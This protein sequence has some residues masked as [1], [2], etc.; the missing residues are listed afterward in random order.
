LGTRGASLNLE[1]ALLAE[2]L[3]EGCGA[4]VHLTRRDETVPAPA[5]KVRMAE[6][7]GAD[8]FLTIGRAGRQDLWTA[9][10]HPGSATGLQWAELFLH[11]ARSLM[12]PD[13]TVAVT[14]S[15]NYLLRHTACPALEVR[16]PGPE[17][18]GREM[19]LSHR[20]WQRAEARAV[21]LS[22][23]SLFSQGNRDVRTLDVAAVIA[24]L[25][26][27][28]PVEDVEWAE[29]DGN[30]AWSPVPARNHA[31]ELSQFA[32]NA[33]DS[34]GDPGLPALLERHT[35]EIRAGAFQQLWLL[36]KS[37]TGYDARL[38]MHNR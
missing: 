6:A 17:T 25:P 28:P 21:L 36:E 35:L 32:A 15:Y 31:G 20:G 1:T 12:A 19:L 9:C 22:I 7:A 11:S 10:H 29:L 16:L 3:L 34:G 8:L 5:E 38:M 14:P 24:G 30:L 26:G 27:A 23:V 2:G 13:D 33:L 37:G 4:E 18:P